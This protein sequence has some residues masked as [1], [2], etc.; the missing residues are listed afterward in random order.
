VDDSFLVLSRDNKKDGYSINFD[1][2]NQVFGIDNNH[3][4]FSEVEK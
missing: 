3:S 2:E 4:F 1:I